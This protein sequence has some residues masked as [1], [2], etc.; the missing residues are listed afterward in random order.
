[1]E[2][3]LLHK[4]TK[5]LAVTDALVNVPSAPP[6]IYDRSNL[7]A[8]GDN[9]DSLSLG[10]VI[11]KGSAAVNWRGTA[12][13]EVRE[14]YAATPAAPEA[15]EVNQNAHA[16]A[17][18]YTGAFTPVLLLHSLLCVCW[19]PFPRAC[20]CRFPRARQCPRQW[21]CHRARVASQGSARVPSSHMPPRSPS[22]T[23]LQRGWERNALLSLYFGPS[24]ASLVDPDS[25]FQSL[26]RRWV[27]APV[28]DKLIYASQRVQPELARWVD[29]VARWEFTTIAPA[30][31]DVQPGT[32]DDFSRAFAPTLGR[33]GERPYARG[34]VQLLDDIGTKL[35]E[36][37]VI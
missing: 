8:I 9:S 7:L 17:H 37:K 30:H 4:D 2:A 35:K 29:D 19:C 32:A 28:T 34:D 18:A 14:L 11:L 21:C 5:V 25:S 22:Q 20:W 13:Q 27:V 24:P 3:A 1:M 10:A 16:H 6:A 12:A 36:L 33:P 15:A 26:Q 23:R 31:F